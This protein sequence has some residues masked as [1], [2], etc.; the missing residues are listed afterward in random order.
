MCQAW[1]CGLIVYNYRQFWNEEW[2]IVYFLFIP[3]T[4]HVS[5]RLLASPHSFF[6]PLQYEL[7]LIEVVFKDLSTCAS[8]Y[9]E[10]TPVRATTI[11]NLENLATVWPKRWWQFALQCER[12]AP[13]RLRGEMPPY[14]LLDWFQSMDHNATVVVVK[15]RKERSPS[16][17]HN[18]NQKPRESCTVAEADLKMGDLITVC[19]RETSRNRKGIGKRCWGGAL[20]RSRSRLFLLCLSRRVS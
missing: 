2:A 7:D 14:Y 13:Y 5:K 17:N 15:I 1:C 6:E 3:V 9:Q 16:V 11:R 20:V 8:W 4:A 10:D 19:Q 18:P 12:Y